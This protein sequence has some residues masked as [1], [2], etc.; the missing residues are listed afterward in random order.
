MNFN[1][2]NIQVFGLPHSGTNFVEWSLRNNFIGL[3]YKVIPSVNNVDG[4]YPKDTLLKHNY[5]TLK[6]SNYA[7]LIYKPFD[8]WQ[9]SLKKHGWSFGVTQYGYQKYIDSAKAL[10]DNCYIIDWKWCCNNYLEFLSNIKDKFGVK[11]IDNPTQPMHRMNGD[12]GLTT[13]EDY[14]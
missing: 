7:I 11:L 12:S 14:V 2:N 8:E 3:D 13:N 4:S 1:H 5:P 9:K 10:G 6:Y